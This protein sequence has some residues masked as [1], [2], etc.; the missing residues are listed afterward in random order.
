MSRRILIANRG[1]IAVRIIRACRELGYTAIAIFSDVDRKSLHVRRAD[2]AYHVGPANPRE[3]YLNIEKIIDIARRAKVDAIHPGYGFLAENAEFARAVEESGLIFIGPPSD[4]LQKSGDKLEARRIAHEADVPYVPGTIEPL[5]SLEHALEVAHSIG[6]PVMLKAVAGG[7]GK[8]MRL[9]R[10]ADEL[11]KAWTVASGEAKSAFGDDRLYIEKSIEHPRHVEMQIILDRYGHGVYLGERECSIQRRHQKVI[12]ESPSV[13]VTSAL[14]EKI[15]KYALAFARQCGYIN[16][17]TVEF[18]MDREKNIYFLEMNAR[19]QVEHP[20]TE[21]VTGFDL[22]KEQIEVAFG[23]K[24]SLAQDDIR[25]RGHAIECRIYAEDPAQNFIPC[26]GQITSLDEPSGPWVRVDSGVYAGWEVPVEYDPLLAKLIV[27]APNRTEAI[28]RMAR[29][30]EEYH[31]TGIATTIPL[32]RMIVQEEK[33]QKGDISTD[34][35]QEL[36]NKQ[37]QPARSREKIALIAGAIAHF[38]KLRTRQGRPTTSATSI[39]AW[40]EHAWRDEMNVHQ[41]DY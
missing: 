14:R 36:L 40:R 20:V 33:F 9:V 3:S 38:E 10:N 25:L 2:E 21:M 32:Y 6:Y 19:I 39:D 15:G 41:F 22:V 30:L 23:K 27:W 34:Y 29:A 8:G 4:V 26:P 17:G 12:E 1:E 11:E 18:L 28:Q 24:L 5:K 37:W 31:I 16:A 35:L 13:V 7:G